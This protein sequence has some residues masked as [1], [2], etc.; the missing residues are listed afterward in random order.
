MKAN[1]NLGRLIA[2]SALGLF[3]GNVQAA[4]TLDLQDATTYAKTGIA[5]TY[6]GGSLIPNN[7]YIGVYGF[8]HSGTP[9]L[10]NNG[11]SG[12]NFW[13]V[14]LD[15]NGRIDWDAHTYERLTFAEA[16]PGL[17]PSKWAYSGSDFWGI[18]NANY[19]WRNAYAG[20]LSGGDKQD[21]GVALTL[22]MYEALYD[23]TQY[24]L[25]VAEDAANALG[26]NHFTVSQGLS[27]DVLT[28]YNQ[29]LS[30][31]S[32]FN[33]ATDIYNGY[34]LKGNPLVAGDN[35]QEFLLIGAPVPEPTTLIAGALLLLPFGV[36]TLR[37]LRKRS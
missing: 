9:V 5:A 22:A 25:T 36:S 16:N 28:Y 37:V 12:N 13:S 34:I 33:S 30:L 35:G 21:M 8:A 10:P 11:P 31:L 26:G 32:G 24:G 3:Y 14:C 17:N 19:I 27:G 20:V 23:S 7:V 2:I 1:A 6:D 18:Q 29:Y 4:I 15:P